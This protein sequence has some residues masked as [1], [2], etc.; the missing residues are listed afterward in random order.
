MKAVDFGGGWATTIDCRV[1]RWLFP[2]NREDMASF[3]P[4]TD[5]S[6]DLIYAVDSK[7]Q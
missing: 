4:Y 5:N 7:S 6:S 1:R 3:Q 2:Q